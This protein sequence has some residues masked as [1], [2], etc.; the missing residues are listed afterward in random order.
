M[1]RAFLFR[2]KDLFATV[3]QQSSPTVRQGIVEA[4]EDVPVRLGVLLT[5]IV[6]DVGTQIEAAILT[7]PVVIKLERIGV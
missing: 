6:V 5:G 3:K 4:A 1:Y 2:G 7:E